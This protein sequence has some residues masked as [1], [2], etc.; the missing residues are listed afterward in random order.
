MI[1]ESGSEC[2]ADIEVHLVITVLSPRIVK[3]NIHMV[4]PGESIPHTDSAAGQYIVSVEVSDLT[5]HLS[6]PAERNDAHAFPSLEAVFR[7]GHEHR[8]VAVAALWI[9]A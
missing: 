8:T 1:Q 3:A 5:R 2:F 4:L 6:E 7:L 9:P